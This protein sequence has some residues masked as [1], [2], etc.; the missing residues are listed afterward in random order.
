MVPSAAKSRAESALPEA[1]AEVDAVVEDEVAA[2]GDGRAGRDRWRVG[3][4]VVLEDEAA[5]VER[6]S[7]RC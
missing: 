1:E 6:R 5:D 7:R 2:G 4:V 3:V